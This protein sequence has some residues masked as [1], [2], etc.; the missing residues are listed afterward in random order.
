MDKYIFAKVMESCKDRKLNVFQ[1]HNALRSLCGSKLAGNLVEGRTVRKDYNLNFLF[2]SE[3]CINFTE[4]EVDFLEKIIQTGASP[5]PKNLVFT[6]GERKYGA[7]NAKRFII[8]QCLMAF[9]LKKC[10]RLKTLAMAS[11]ESAF[12]Y[13]DA[14]K[15]CFLEMAEDYRLSVEEGD[16]KSL[17]AFSYITLFKDSGD[18]KDEAEKEKDKIKQRAQKLFAFVN[19]YK[20]LGL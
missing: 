7:H 13:Y 11:K 3:S 12:H 4:N 15:T 17:Y 9:A 2:R 20:A 14:L 8:K 16:E 1:T 6:R 10:Y 5:L 18:L 19:S